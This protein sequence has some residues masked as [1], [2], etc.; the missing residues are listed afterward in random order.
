LPG[1]REE[2]MRAMMMAI[3]FVFIRFL[4]DA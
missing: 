1:K 4:L 3:M 2:V